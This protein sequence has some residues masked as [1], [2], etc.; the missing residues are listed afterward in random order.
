MLRSGGVLVVL[1]GFLRGDD[2][3]WL[4]DGEFELRLAVVIESGAGGDQA[5]H[6]DVFLKA[7]EVTDTPGNWGQGVSAITW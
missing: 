2:G 3:F 5:T 1:E 6:D 4:L 7:A